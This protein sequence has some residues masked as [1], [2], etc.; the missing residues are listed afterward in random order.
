MDSKRINH[1]QSLYFKGIPSLVPPPSQGILFITIRDSKPISK[2]LNP[3]ISKTFSGYQLIFSPFIFH[4]KYLGW[5]LFFIV[6]QIINAFFLNLIEINKILLPT[7]RKGNDIW[8]N[9]IPAPC[10][11]PFQ[12]QQS[13]RLQSLSV[14][15]LYRRIYTVVRVS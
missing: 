15:L 6:M 4:Q 2:P 3:F 5:F 12:T 1:S 9:A 14:C 13:I 7:S 10:T 8:A 11:F